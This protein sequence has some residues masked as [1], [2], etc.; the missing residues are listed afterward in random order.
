M[1]TD[2]DVLVLEHCVLYKAEQ[3]SSEKRN[4]SYELD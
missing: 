3:P 4:D 1:N 2:M